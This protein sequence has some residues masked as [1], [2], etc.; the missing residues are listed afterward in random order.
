MDAYMAAAEIDRAA[1]APLFRSLDRRRNLTDR[2]IHRCEILAMIKRRSRQ[3]GLPISICC[4]KF[5]AAGITA[6]LTNGGTLENVQ[7]IAAH[8]SPR[9]TRL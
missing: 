4:H 2:R 1:K 7:R 6:Y 5:R 8:E 9:T 3:S